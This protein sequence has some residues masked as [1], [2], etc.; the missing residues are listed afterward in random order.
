VR[1]GFRLAARTADVLVSFREPV[2]YLLRGNEPPSL[3]A[4]IAALE[5]S[6]QPV[7]RASIDAPLLTI[8]IALAFLRT[9][10]S[11]PSTVASILGS[12]L[13]TLF[14]RNSRAALLRMPFAIHLGATLAAHGVR[15][16]H[17]ASDLAATL[18]WIA[19]RT[20]GIP[21][22][23]VH[24]P[25]ASNLAQKQA[26][27][28]FARAIGT[29]DAAAGERLP[30]GAASAATLPAIFEGASAHSTE[31]DTIR[32]LPWD[33]LSAHH[34]G[35][36]WSSIRYDAAVAE[37]ALFAGEDRRHIIVKQ[38]R[39]TGALAESAAKRARNER[40]AL[41]LLAA[42][43]PVDRTVP[44]LLHY[45]DERLALFM[46]KAAGDPLDRLFG[47]AARGQVRL[48]E[49][50][51][52]AT[53]AAEW[54]KA[55]QQVTRREGESQLTEA[56]KLA[57]RDLIHV[58]ERDLA[59][60]RN[61]DLLARR[62]DDLAAGVASRGNIVTG[63]HGDFWP[64]NV[65]IAPDVVTVIDFEGYREGLPAEDVA[66][67]MLRT[68]LLSRRF[69]LMAPPLQKTFAEAWGGIRSDELLLFTITKA[70][71]TYV[72]TAAGNQARLQK[73]WTI[74]ALRQALL[75][76]LRQ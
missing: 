61:A 49:L 50:E 1:P 14:R 4:E 41:T 19:S 65:F 42:R 11:R 35:V 15:H 73:L 30:L 76:T 68:E 26:N 45:D 74:R 25:N 46:E 38:Q 36:R 27:A 22:S 5:E 2:A 23:F 51:R 62:L 33:A 7:V 6:G 55:M 59:V 54:L 28:A 32:S 60:R 10:A 66:Y 3:D 16:L 21:F 12:L 18:A 63:H 13:T 72:N 9:S 39:R 44:R 31:S 58:A 37:V 34:V 64:G 48:A 40:D 17:A 47:A 69:G 8:P 56:I 70:L 52:G 67:F 24:D 71:R 53:R 57:Q 75:R 29:Q 43:L 20:A